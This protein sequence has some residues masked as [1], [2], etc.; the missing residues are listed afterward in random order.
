MIII[1]C[2]QSLNLAIL[3]NNIFLKIIYLFMNLGILI[4]GF[5]S[6]GFFTNIP[7]NYHIII[8]IAFLIYTLYLFIQGF[9]LKSSNSQINILKIVIFVNLFF[10][11][12]LIGGYLMPT[13]FQSILGIFQILIF[14]SIFITKKKHILLFFILFSLFFSFFSSI[15][16][17][18]DL[19]YYDR[20]TFQETVNYLN[21]KPNVDI[22]S[23][24]TSILSEIGHNSIILFHSPFHFR[25]EK[26]IYF[27]EGIE[28]KY[29]NKDISLSKKE[30]LSKLKSEKPEIIFGSWRAT[31]RLFEDIEWREFLEENYQEEKKIGRITIYRLIS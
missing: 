18:N 25:E 28:K 27:Y 7:L 16:L 26:D 31:F 2:L 20:Q 4:F 1:I 3:K 30:I 6:R 9:Q 13:R 11:I 21:S 22:F 5:G 24:D 10:A 15:N 14:G 23:A 19:T 12:S 8:F 29:F 17:S